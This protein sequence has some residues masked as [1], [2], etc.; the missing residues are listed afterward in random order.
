M[1]KAS[2]QPATCRLLYAQ[3]LR[4]IRQREWT[5]QRPLLA[6][7]H[8]PRARAC[9]VPVERVTAASI[10]QGCEFLHDGWIRARCGITIL[11][12][13]CEHTLCCAQGMQREPRMS[14]ATNWPPHRGSHFRDRTQWSAPHY[15]HPPTRPQPSR[16]ERT[17]L[18]GGFVAVCHIPAVLSCF[19]RR[20]PDVDRRLE[21]EQPS[22][23]SPHGSQV[24]LAPTDELDALVLKHGL[25]NC[26]QLPRAQL[27][28]GT[29]TDFAACQC[30]PCALTRHLA[31]FVG[32]VVQAARRTMICVAQP[33]LRFQVSDPCEHPALQPKDWT[34]QQQFALQA[35][36]SFR[37]PCAVGR[38]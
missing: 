2:Q 16:W 9:T 28:G 4:Q 11:L 19:G 23:C 27:D 31:Q 38:G 37:M 13:R 3:K 22:T 32:G 10:C 1:P 30:C 36:I 5:P 15:S 6:Q 20:H 7:Q 17:A 12:T 14:N 35:V 34:W 8:S 25:A 21:A 24:H 18:D 29:P 33:C 26:V